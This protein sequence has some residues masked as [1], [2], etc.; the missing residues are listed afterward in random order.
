MA[1]GALAFSIQFGENKINVHGPALWKDLAF[2]LRGKPA[3]PGCG[4]FCFVWKGSMDS[5]CVKLAEAGAPIEEGP[6]ERL[7]ARNAGRAMGTSVYTRDPDRN[8]LEFI[9]YPQT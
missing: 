8:L 5:L 4:D 6:V 7:G 2:T 3:L 1:S 9:V